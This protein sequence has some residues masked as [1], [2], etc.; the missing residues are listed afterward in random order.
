MKPL[1]FSTPPVPGPARVQVQF[2]PLGVG[3]IMSW[4]VESPALMLTL[5]PLI[6]AIAC[7]NAAVVK[8]S[9]VA[10][11]TADMIARLLPEYL[12][13]AAFS[14][15]LGAKA[16]TTSLWNSSGTTFSSPVEMQLV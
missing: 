11:A 12:D 10:P 5:S 7:G 14:V 13:Q 1:S 9:E 2:D 15:V 6:A 3:L 16:E 8:P 4:D